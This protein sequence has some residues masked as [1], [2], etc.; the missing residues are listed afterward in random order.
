VTTGPPRSTHL[1]QCGSLAVHG[2][3]RP[4]PAVRSEHLQ[5]ARV[6]SCSLGLRQWRLLVMNRSGSIQG[7]GRRLHVDPVP[8]Q[9]LPQRLDPF[10]Q[11]PVLLLQSLHVTPRYGTPSKSICGPTLFVIL[12]ARRASSGQ[13][14]AFGFCGTVLK[15]LASDAE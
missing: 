3:S 12:S 4:S 7:T 6:P 2:T 13:S 5:V 1:G 10:P 9:A 8:H 15:M 14:I 11:V